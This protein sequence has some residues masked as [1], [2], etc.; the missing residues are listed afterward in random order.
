MKLLLYTGLLLSIFSCQRGAGKIVL[1]SGWGDNF[2]E[3]KGWCLKSDCIDFIFQDT[4][5]FGYAEYNYIIS[6]SEAR[7]YKYLYIRIND[8][9]SISLPTS[10]VGLERPIDIKMSEN[11]IHLIDFSLKNLSK[12][13][14]KKWSSA[15]Q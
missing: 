12:R 6:V 10:A 4:I 11:G 2:I 15:G 14:W 1:G 3:I 8:Q 5:P 7:K 9:A 13:D